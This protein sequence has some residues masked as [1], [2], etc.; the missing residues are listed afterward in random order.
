VYNFTIQNKKKERKTMETTINDLKKELYSIHS[1]T[2]GL[3]EIEKDSKI[4]DLEEVGD[5]LVK[6]QKQIE[7]LGKSK[8]FFGR[9]TD[10][11]PIL[12]RIKKNTEHELA[13]QQELSD[14]ITSTLANFEK[15]YEDLIVYLK[16][17]ETTK[18]GFSDDIIKLDSWIERATA[19]GETLDSSVD[20][21]ALERLMVEAKSELKRKTDSLS[22]LIEPI[23]I[24]ATHLTRNINELTPILKNILYTE[25]K[26]MVGVNSF[27]NAANMMITLKE[28]IV[29]IQKLNVI[30]TNEAIVD[31]LN[32]TKT[33]LLTVKDHEEMDKLREKGRKEIEKAVTEIK[34]AQAENAKFMNEQYEKL[35]GSGALRIENLKKRDNELLIEAI[36]EDLK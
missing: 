27:K 17:F 29:E 5:M 4:V 34:K 12:G 28:S 31:I 10:N 36:P 8:G 7:E 2:Q 15:K 3:Q 35:K 21:L 16:L 30:N 32:N 26:T 11:L 20:K 6:V 23:I 22:T 25:L 1:S 9:L 24:A 13:L 33:N 18:S 14:Y 19:Y